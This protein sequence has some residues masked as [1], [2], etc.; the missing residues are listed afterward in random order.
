[1]ASKYL[2]KSDIIARLEFSDDSENLSDEESQDFDKEN[3]SGYSHQESVEPIQQVTLVDYSDNDSDNDSSD[4]IPQTPKAYSRANNSVLPGCTAAICRLHCHSKLGELRRKM[5]NKDYWGKSAENRRNWIAVSCER[6]QQAT[7]SLK[8]RA[9]IIYRLQN[10]CGENVQVCQTFFLATLGLKERR[11]KMIRTVFDSISVGETLPS[12]S[13]QG[14]HSKREIYDREIIKSH[15]MSYNPQIS[16][17]RRLHA[18]NRLYLPSEISVRSMHEDFIKNNKFVSL[19]VYYKSV[20]ELNISFTKLGEEECEIC[21]KFTNHKIL[22]QGNQ[23]DCDVCLKYLAHQEKFR[24]AR[25]HY[26]QDKESG[27]FAVAIDLQKVLILPYMNQHKTAIFTPRLVTFNETFARLGQATPSNPNVAVL[28][29]EAIS[30]RSASDIASTYW[31]FFLEVNCNEPIVLWLDNCSAQNKNWTLF[32]MLVKAVNHF[33]FE[34]ITLKFFE[35]GHT[36]MAADSVHAAI[37]KQ[38]KKVQKIN[39]FSD[40]IA[41]VEKSNRVGIK[42]IPLSFGD[43]LDFTD[44]TSATKLK[45]SG[46]PKL[47]DM[48]IVQFRTTSKKLFYGLDHHGGTLKPFDFLKKDFKFTLPSKKS[49]PRGIQ[50]AKKDKICT[51]LLPLMPA[52]HHPFWRDLPQNDESNDLLRVQ[53]IV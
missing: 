15:I 12:P 18:P 3:Q 16:H 9:N 11:D 13:R 23:T 53:E 8:R 7:P 5:I 43:F 38:M 44:E 52:K 27:Q 2:S 10:G 29:H 36:F 6:Q 4:F 37:E 25:E 21:T 22:C 1:M 20:Q 26:T 42:T 30:G 48:Y 14:K 46:R 50:K 41:V 45:A 35:P 31:N 51:N 49:K 34:S 24:S 32:S 33:E 19:S 28:W 40:F 17:Y 47:A 39:D